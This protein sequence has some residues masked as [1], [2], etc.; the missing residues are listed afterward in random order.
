MKLIEKMAREYSGP[1]GDEHQAD[2]FE[3]GFRA[4][5]KLLRKQLSD[6]DSSI[7]PTGYFWDKINLLGEEEVE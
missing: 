1:Y 2:A 3:A 5:K 6:C 7:D 4:A